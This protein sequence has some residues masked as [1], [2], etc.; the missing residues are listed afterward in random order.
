MFSNYPP[1]VTGN[2][3]EIAGPDYEETEEVECQESA[4][5]VP[6]LV[7]K[8]LAAYAAV[9]KERLARAILERDE[10]EIL[11]VT[12]LLILHIEGAASLADSSKEEGV[13]G[14]AGPADVQGYRNQRWWTCPA[15]GAEH[16]EYQEDHRDFY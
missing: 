1:G 5:M 3:F 2:E 6:A 14:Y 12:R 11:A 13:C 15:C 4:E 8:G 7:I 9:L 16:E 10:F